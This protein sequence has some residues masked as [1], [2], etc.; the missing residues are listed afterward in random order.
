MVDVMSALRAE[1]RQ[2]PESGIVE[3]VNFARERDDLI[4]LWVGEGDL[5]TPDFIRAAAEASLEKGETFYTYQRGA[6]RGA[7]ALSS[8]PFRPRLGGGALFRYRFGHAGDPDC[9]PGD[10]RCRR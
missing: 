7:G 1:A 10:S 3:V 9:G 8:A 5:P 2:A 4:P 6:A